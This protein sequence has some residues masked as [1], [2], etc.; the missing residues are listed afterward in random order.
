MKKFRFP[1]LVLF[2][3]AFIGQ[4]CEKWRDNRDPQ[5]ALDNALAE[6]SFL[7]VF[8]IVLSETKEY[9]GFPSNVD[10]CSSRV[11]VSTNGTASVFRVEYGSS[12]CSSNY[13][14]TRRGAVIIEITES[15]SNDNAQATVTFEDFYAKGYRV[16]GT[17]IIKNKGVVDGKTQ[18][19]MTVSEGKIT[20][21]TDEIVSWNCDLTF[22]RS[23]GQSSLDFVWDDV[24][25]VTGEA[26][27][28]SV[29]GRNFTTVVKE[30]LNFDMT[31]RW[32]IKGKSEIEPEEL[33]TITVSYGDGNCDN[34]VDA[35]IGKK[36]Y[37][38]KLK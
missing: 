2:A 21:S 33:K 4:G 27:G 14:F 3:I 34:D 26:I 17:V 13:N 11:L 19:G 8:R 15:F 16:E 7:D 12:D 38:P 36:E 24:F 5:T 10:S 6:S 20:S 31:C 30:A 23:E 25:S 32:I 37:S 1:L 29:D 18:Y 28:M 9:E 22:D 35:E